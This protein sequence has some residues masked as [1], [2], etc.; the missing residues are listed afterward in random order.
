[1]R[2]TN[3]KNCGA[4]L[5]PDGHCEYCGTWYGHPAETVL[6]SD[7]RPA[8]VLREMTAYDGLRVEKTEELIRECP[9]DWCGLHADIADISKLKVNYIYV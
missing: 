6:Y 2:S 4:V 9:S 7:G 1:M 8:Y 5:P 3:C